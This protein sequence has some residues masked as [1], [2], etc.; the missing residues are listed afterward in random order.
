[1]AELLRLGKPTR[2]ERQMHQ[3]IIQRHAED[4]MEERGYRATVDMAG[5]P[6]R[7][8]AVL[9]AA[10]RA[11]LSPRQNTDAWEDL[12]QA[13]EHITDAEI[14]DLTNAAF[15]EKSE[16]RPEQTNTP[17][18]TAPKPKQQEERIPDEEADHIARVLD[19]GCEYCGAR[20]GL[21]RHTAPR[22]RRVKFRCVDADACNARELASAA[23]NSHLDA[24]G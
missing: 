5:L 7:V 21:E 24:D 18:I 4:F 22:S 6:A 11:T 17:T 1:M 12:I 16:N 2:L 9:L 23:A 14:I 15:A 10:H 19:V 3:Q 8:R 13:C 20:T